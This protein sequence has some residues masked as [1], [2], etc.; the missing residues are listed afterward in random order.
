MEARE[1][2]DVVL[3]I[4]L[5]DDEFKTSFDEMDKN[6][7]GSVSYKEFKK[8]FKRLDKQK[9]KIEFEEI[10]LFTEVQI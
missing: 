6:K 8:Y 1:A 5:T 10:F 7:D 9:E 2:F 4:T 3:K